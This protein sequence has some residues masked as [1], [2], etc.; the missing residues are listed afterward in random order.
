MSLSSS[1]YAGISGL[2]TMGNGMSVLGDNVANVNTIAF[3]SSRSTFQDVLSQSV[4]TAAGSAQVG[5]GVTLTT[6]DGLFAQGSF[7]STSTPTDLAI[8]GEGFFM[9][10][11]S[12]SAEADMYT[13]AGEF[14][15][16]TQGYLTSP[17]GHFVQGWNVDAVTGQIQGTIG[18]INLGRATPPVAT[19]RID[20]IVNVDSRTPR[21]TT[22]Q[23]LFDA[24]NGTNMAAVNPTSPIDAAN[25]EYTTAIKV[26]D[27]KGAAHDV[28]IYFDRT[29]QD[30]QYE[31]LVTCDPA[32]DLRTL[33]EREQVIYAPNERYNYEQHKGAGALMYGVIDFNTSGAITAINAW[34]VP[35][36]GK[37]DP[38]QNTNRIALDPTDNYYSFGANFTGAAD[39]Q[40]IELNFGARY[41]GQTT[42]Q[43]QILVTNNGAYSD[44]N[45]TNH[46]TRETLW[47][48]VYD[49]NGNRMTGGDRI[50]V[51]GFDNGGYY[52]EYTHTVNGNERVGIFLE[53]LGNQFGAT[54]TIDAAGRIRITDNSPG[55]SGLAITSFDVFSANEADPFGGGDRVENVTAISAAP[56]VDSAGSPITAVTTALIGVGSYDG[57]D[58]PVRTEL[59]DGDTIVFAGF[60]TGNNLV[61]PLAPASTFTVG[62]GTTV[63]DLLAFMSNLYS[64]NPGDVTATLDSSGRI[65]L[66]DNTLGGDLRAEVISFAG[67]PNP[68]IVDDFNLLSANIGGTINVAT[69]K[70]ELIAPAQAFSTDSGQPPVITAGTTWDSV[71]DAAGNPIGAGLISFT[72]TDR[73]GTTVNGSYT[74]NLADEP[75][76]TVQN[77]LDEIAETFNADAFIDRAGRLIIR[78]RIS[79][80]PGED[81]KSQLSFSITGYPG[82]G[83]VFGPANEGFTAIAGSLE[84]DGSRMGTVA[85]RNFETE[86]MSTTQ[87]A[88]SSTT[89][90]QDQDGFAAGFL[91]SV[92]VD[93]AGIITGNYSNGQ[94]LMRAQVALANFANLQGLHKVGGNI[95]R[96]TTASGAPVTGQPGTNGLGSISPNSLEQSNVDLGTEFVKL[97]TTQRGFQANSKIITTTDEMLNDLINIKR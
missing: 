10:R 82:A 95:F 96:T 77:L 72:G 97:I 65:R 79:D 37:V 11:A 23:R 13:R 89:I 75:P 30:N 43:A 48:D 59:D 57:S 34:N 1:L 29:T 50:T 33:D 18:D 14:R 91:Q 52:R 69:T 56:L 54:A 93:T 4:A 44:A 86:A 94:V 60:D 22:E 26:Y 88:N 90:Y 16:N 73:N 42:N 38:A 80:G 70:R 17:S 53:N 36:D 19:E 7:E 67:S 58:P 35:P 55:H 8:G 71:Y 47:Q 21:E 81:E 24:W 3:K 92:S 62:V 20:L 51:A 78:D 74:I 9:L 31:F 15:F 27:S 76:H 66:L 83:G 41:S 84:E 2:S 85:S 45:A 40:M 6:V 12:D 32:S 61:D 39:N 28:T 63:A 87:Y 5:R 46:I 68:L 64:A 49:V 25:F